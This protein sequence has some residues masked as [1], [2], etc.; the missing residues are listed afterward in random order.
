MVINQAVD[1]RK[2]LAAAFKN[3][4]VLMKLDTASWKGRGFLG[5]NV[6]V[7]ESTNFELK[8]LAVPIQE[9]TTATLQEI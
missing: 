1:Y 7:I 5:I 6:Q 3:K 9:M 2:S 4:L 8:T